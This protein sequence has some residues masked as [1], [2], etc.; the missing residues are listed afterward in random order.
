MRPWKAGDLYESCG[1][2]P[3]LCTD[4][5]QEDSHGGLYGI[6]L[7]DGSEGHGCSKVACAP[8][9]L[10][11]EQAL[12]M[13][14]AILNIRKERPQLMTAD[15]VRALMRK[16]IDEKFGGMQGALAEDMAVTA[17][18]VSDLLN[19]HRDIPLKG[20]VLEYFGLEARI[21]WEPKP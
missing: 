3:V 2:H 11:L 10:T 4:A 19:K 7:V 8:R 21:T 5:E 12:A 13:R 14:A 20:P 16:T 15:D 6:S 17:Q 1:G 9:R 18:Y